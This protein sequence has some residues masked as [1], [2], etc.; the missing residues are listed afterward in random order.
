[1]FFAVGIL[2][3]NTGVGGGAAE[4]GTS[5]TPFFDGFKAVFGEGV[6]ASCSDSSR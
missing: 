6:G 3:L 1:M 4:I 2:F 5:A